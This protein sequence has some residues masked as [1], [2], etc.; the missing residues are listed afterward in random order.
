MHGLKKKWVLISSVTALTVSLLAGCGNAANEAN[1]SVSSATGGVSKKAE[2]VTISMFIT[3]ASQKDWQEGSA[4][5]KLK[6]EW[7]AKTGNKL[8]LNILPGSL[9]EATKKIDISMVSGD[10][11]DLIGLTN[12]LDQNKYASKGFLYPL[13]DLAK[14]ANYD[15]DKM[16]G[17]SLTKY[18]GEVYYIPIN[19]S[20][21]AV[22][23]NKKI[24]DE[25]GVPYPSG[26]W[27][28]SQY[29]ETAK[30]LTKPEKG[31]YGSYMLTFDNYLYLQAR[32]KD[33]PGYKQDGT[34]NYD[35]P[36]FK[37]ALKWFNDLSGVHKIQPSWIEFKTKKLSNLGFLEGKYAM[38]FI[39]TWY[40]GSLNNWEKYPRDWKWGVVQ[41]PVPDDGKGN[42]NIGVTAA[43]GI[44][45][46]SAHPKEAFDFLT[47][48]AE[49]GYKV[50]GEFPAQKN[51][52]KEDMS[53]VLQN[54]ADKSQGSVTTEDL[55]KA[56]I[57]NGLG[58]TQE[59][60]LGTAMSE[61]SNIVMQESELYFA[62]QKSLDEAVKGIKQREDQAI[63]EASK[64]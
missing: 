22:F 61:Y 62:G 54:I 19:L 25:A 52:S 1:G 59:K 11:T 4:N 34:S 29:I 13:T 44:N 49:N 38:H 45:K 16:Y 28:W 64:Q 9:E 46:K 42:N 14:K 8:E 57:D 36:A 18:K 51:L 55:R 33:V 48:F 58:F 35:D 60:L 37:D 2:P 32:Q 17:E 56:L 40:L 30:K 41:P 53:T 39:G 10:T 5:D 7:E 26:K 12:P 15:M 50:R 21:W 63:R 23:Y 27:T 47:F 43:Y 20:M 24:F 31:I 6:K 3:S